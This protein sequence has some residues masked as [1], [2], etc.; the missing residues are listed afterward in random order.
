VSGE[1]RQTTK[2]G[3]EQMKDQVQRAGRV[4]ERRHA[5]FTLIEMLAVIAIIAVLAG[6][7]VGLTSRSSRAS[8]D[9]KLK[10]MRDQLVTAIEDYK[11]QFGYYPPDNRANYPA[12]PINA[13]TNPLYYELT[14]TVV[15]NQRGVFFTPDRSEEIGVQTVRDFFGVEGFV[16]AVPSTGNLAADTR[17]V[18]RFIELK[19]EQMG[20][21]VPNVAVL[22]APVRWPLNP[23]P[24]VGPAPVPSKPGLNPWRYVSTNPTNNPGRFDLWA[25]FVDGTSVKIICNWNQGILDKP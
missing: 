23:R 6:L 14:G 1:W 13:V 4:F 11:S 16:N 15:D 8:R 9:S 24:E 25:E 22:T 2:T 20:E 18:R 19:S 10:V 21:I 3:L 7:V 17:L 12:G 5:G